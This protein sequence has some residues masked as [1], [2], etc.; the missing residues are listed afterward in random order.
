MI[1]MLRSAEAFKVLGV[2]KSVAYR[3]VREGLLTPPIPVA[4][5][6][7]CWPSYELDLINKARIA[8]KSDDALRA[9]VLKLIER[10]G[11]SAE[12]QPTAARGPLAKKLAKAERL[13]N[14]KTQ[15]A[16]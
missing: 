5:N 10:R 2:S 9:L 1:T 4:R 6:S 15:A 14:D 11:A 3:K 16:P 12:R 13:A 8:Q 7:V